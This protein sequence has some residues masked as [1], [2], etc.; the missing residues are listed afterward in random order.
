MI[1]SFVAFHPMWTPQAITLL[2]TSQTQ[3]QK[4]STRQHDAAALLTGE[5][6]FVSL[7][8]EAEII[9]WGVEEAL[10]IMHWMFALFFN[11]MQKSKVSKCPA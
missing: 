1:E 5:Q 2:F 6:N 3:V 9:V 8:G 10:V 7:L 11:S 4:A